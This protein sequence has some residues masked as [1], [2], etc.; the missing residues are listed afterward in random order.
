MI[1]LINKEEA[2]DK[3]NIHALKKVLSTFGK[4]ENFLNLT[5]Q[6]QKP[7]ADIILSGKTE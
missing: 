2:S 3:F 4:Q 1:S 6:L 5:G 7:I